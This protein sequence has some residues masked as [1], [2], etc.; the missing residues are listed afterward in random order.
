MA[1]EEAEH[2]PGAPRPLPGLDEQRP[3]HRQPAAAGDT[4]LQG[5]HAQHEGGVGDAFQPG[6]AALGGDEAG[7]R[8]TPP[9]AAAPAGQRSRSVSSGVYSAGAPKV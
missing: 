8:P 3:A 1:E 5:P 6:T 2:R 4:R 7:T 9:G